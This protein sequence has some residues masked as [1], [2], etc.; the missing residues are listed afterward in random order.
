M[1]TENVL[2]HRE[3]LRL[4]RPGRR[5]TSHSFRK[6]VADLTRNQDAFPLLITTA[7]RVSTDKSFPTRAL[8]MARHES[9]GLAGHP[10]LL[11][12]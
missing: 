2:D 7:V 6:T 1:T 8:E 3:R 5:L 9:R 12:R 4:A 11:I 10:G